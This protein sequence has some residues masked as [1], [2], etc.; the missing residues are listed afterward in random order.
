MAAFS[1]AH[2]ETFVRG[3]LGDRYVEITEENIARSRSLRGL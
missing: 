1:A 2:D 3:I